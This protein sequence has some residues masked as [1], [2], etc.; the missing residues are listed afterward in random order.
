M[1]QSRR[2]S[3]T[4]RFVFIGLLLTAI[5]A[6]ATLT[7]AGGTQT[8]DSFTAVPGVGID[9]DALAT[10]YAAFTDALIKNNQDASQAGLD[11]QYE[12]LARQQFTSAMS[13]AGLSWTE[14]DSVGSAPLQAMQGGRE[15]AVMDINPYLLGAGASVVD[16]KARDPETGKLTTCLRHAQPSDLVR[17]VEGLH[18][19]PEN[20]IHAGSVPSHA[21]LPRLSHRGRQLRVQPSARGGI[22][23]RQSRGAPS[24][25]RHGG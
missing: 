22:S 23:R 4:L 2:T 6:F 19:G 24:D 18:D 9:H 1:A 3:H 21:L 15:E 17:A 10:Q 13:A 16:L 14:V 5:A 20:D 25:G 7:G 12:T 11:G 8:S